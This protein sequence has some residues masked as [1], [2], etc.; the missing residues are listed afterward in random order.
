MAR[1]KK[2]K[3]D[4]GARARVLDAAEKLYGLRGYDG[5][6]LR[7]IASEA[8]I[9]HS[10]IYFHAPGGK[11][12]LYVEVMVRL[13]ERHQEALS[14]IV[15]ESDGDLIAQLNGC[16]RWIASNPPVD[17]LRM[18]H[19]DYGHLAPK[20]VRKLGPLTG[21]AFLDPIE[22][23]LR[24]AHARG[25]IREVDFKVAAGG[26]FSMLLMVHAIPAGV[27]TKSHERISRELVEVFLH[28]LVDPS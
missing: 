7:D 27:A 21:A 23:A 18:R 14:G 19:V 26:L 1:G 22:E 4:S 17:T 13:L 15:A 9:D 10:S 12:A 6:R 24:S 11:E 20:H 5:V 8:G 25:E 3:G 2:Q 28:G 16:A